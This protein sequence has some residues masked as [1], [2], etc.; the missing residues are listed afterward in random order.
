VEHNIARLMELP[1]RLDRAEIVRRG[2]LG[3]VLG[4]SQAQA[5]TWAQRSDFPA[6]AAWLQARPVWDRAEVERWANEHH[7]TG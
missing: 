1:P 3:P 2:D 5:L 7:P 4:V 6:P